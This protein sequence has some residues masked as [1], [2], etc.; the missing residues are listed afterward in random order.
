MEDPNE[1]MES[2]NKKVKMEEAAKKKL[3]ILRELRGSR[4]ALA[5]LLSQLSPAMLFVLLRMARADRD[6]AVDKNLWMLVATEY[7]ARRANTSLV[8]V[9]NI[10][11][12]YG[13]E[14]PYNYFRMILMFH[15]IH[16]VLYKNLFT[17]NTF[18]TFNEIKEERNIGNADFDSD[19]MLFKLKG[20][21][22]SFFL[23]LRYTTTD[24]RPLLIVSVL[25]PANYNQSRKL[26]STLDAHPGILRGWR[27]LLRGTRFTFTLYDEFEELF[28]ILYHLLEAYENDLYIVVPFNEN[29]DD[30]GPT[31]TPSLLNINKNVF[32]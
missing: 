27:V 32:Y 5:V 7:F 1:P 6:F 8:Q 17:N 28:V 14:P 12:Q 20:T 16:T 26:L 15:L 2:K 29:D 18:K 10:L 21:K 23:Q 9:E 3:V 31:T 24:V 13:F 30:D 22:F 4:E 25:H 19:R 11:E